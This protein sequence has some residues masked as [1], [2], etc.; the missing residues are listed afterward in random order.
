MDTKAIDCKK[1]RDA[2]KERSFCPE[3]EIS[4]DGISA[5]FI[6]HCLENVN[7][8]TTKDFFKLKE[9]P[10]RLK[11]IND[12]FYNVCC[13]DYF[14]LSII[15]YDV[16]QRFDQVSK[17]EKVYLHSSDFPDIDE[18]VKKDYFRSEKDFSNYEE[19]KAALATVKITI[20]PTHG[21]NWICIDGPKYLADD[22]KNIIN[23]SL[24]DTIVERIKFEDD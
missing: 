12:K 2:F 21:D 16:K 22:A 9:V 4:L 19:I 14:S 11:Y 15:E 24:K 5:S 7:M 10:A 3:K 23:Q 13:I 20:Y 17:N 18:G 8:K 6:E 1:I